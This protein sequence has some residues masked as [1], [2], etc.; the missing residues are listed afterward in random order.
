MKRLVLILLVVCLLTGCG[1]QGELP[2]A[3]KEAQAETS[4]AVNI[5]IANSSV[6]QQTE[7]AVKVYVPEDA[8]YIGMATMGDK[9]VLASDL[10][11]LILMDAESGDLGASIKVGET[12]VR[13][14]R[15]LLPG[16][17]SGTGVFGYPAAA[18]SQGGDS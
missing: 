14:W 16:R 4:K 7:G 6:E 1:P 17:W 5:Y 3:E 2:S 12:I 11:E 13:A 18:E 9:V 8:T 10:T 15:Q